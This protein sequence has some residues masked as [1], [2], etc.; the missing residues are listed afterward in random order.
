MYASVRVSRFVRSFSTAE[1]LVTTPQ[2][3]RKA[4]TMLHFCTTPNTSFLSV[5]RT[6]HHATPLFV[7]LLSHEAFS[8]RLEPEGRVGDVGDGLLHVVIEILAHL[9]GVV[10]LDHLLQRSEAKAE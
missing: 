8:D 10:A 1:T 6:T 3:R 2:G 9:G 4:P 7:S 5:S